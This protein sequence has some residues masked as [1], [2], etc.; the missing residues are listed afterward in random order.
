[1]LGSMQTSL[2]E[3]DNCSYQFGCKATCCALFWFFPFLLFPVCVSICLLCV[4][5]IEREKERERER[6]MNRGKAGGQTCYS[7][8]VLR[9]RYNYCE[10]EVCL[11]IGLSWLCLGL[12]MFWLC[13]LVV[14]SDCP[15]LTT[16]CLGCV[17]LVSCPGCSGQKWSLKLRL[18]ELSAC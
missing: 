17:L 12:G 1:M 5:V 4:C 10:E 9:F 14:C 18:R 16:S 3:R 2:C 8:C 13:V 11:D 15:V 7:K 6:E